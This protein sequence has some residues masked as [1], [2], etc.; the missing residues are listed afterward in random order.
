MFLSL[1]YS[2]VQGKQCRHPFTHRLLPIITD[3]MVDMQLGTGAVK[4]TPAHDHTDFLLS[5]KHA[6]PRLTV[7]GG[8]GTMTP[9]CGQ[10][11]QVLALTVGLGSER[12]AE[13]S[14]IWL[15]FLQ[16]CDGSVGLHVS[17][18]IIEPLLK[19][20]WFVSCEEMAQKAV[21]AV[22]DGQL[23]IIP[24]YYTKTWN[25]WLSNIRSAPCVCVCVVM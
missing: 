23:E 13:G 22:E 9:P 1:W 21:Q 15:C 7:I 25:N 16:H 2:A 6:L 5:Q 14:F 12:N 4:V 20:Q 8:D 17:G 18:D 11:L 10:W 19:K 3:P 24:H